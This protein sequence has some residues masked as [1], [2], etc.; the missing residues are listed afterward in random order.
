MHIIDSKES[1]ISNETDK[2][3]RIKLQTKIRQ[4][5]FRKVHGAAYR[6]GNARRMRLKRHAQKEK[7]TGPLEAMGQ[8]SSHLQELNA[9]TIIQRTLCTQAKGQLQLP[10]LIDQVDEGSITRAE[11]DQGVSVTLG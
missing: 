7:V 5:R 1:N 2:A 8:K 10:Q 4:A 6:E 9:L 3:K 11:E